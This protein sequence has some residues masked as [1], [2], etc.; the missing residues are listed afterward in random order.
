MAV[1][2]PGVE[3][4][5][6]GRFAEMVVVAESA[7]E[8]SHVRSGDRVVIY[9]DTQRNKYQV[10]GFYA[11]SL[12]LG[13]ET[14]IVLNTPRKDPN[15]QPFAIP[16][17]A[18]K[19]ADTVIDLSSASWIYTP[20]FSEI[21]RSG[22]RILSCMSNVDS[23]IK[24]PPDDDNAKQARLAAKIIDKGK[25]IRVRSSVGTD[26]ILGKEG[27]RGDF[28]DGLLEDK[29]GDWDNFPSSGCACCSLENEANGK[30]VIDQ[31]DILLQLKHF[32]SEPIVCK[33]ESGRIVS[34]DGGIDAKILRDWFEQWDDPNSYV[35]SHVGF[36]CDPRTELGT[37]QLMEWEAY[38]GGLLIAFGRNDSFFTDGT[39]AS[40]SHLD[41]TM[42]N[43]DFAVDGQLLLERGVI[44]RD[45]LA[46]AE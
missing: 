39:N 45:V 41:I 14:C 3:A 19:E 2:Y 30:L 23:C 9:T 38:G 8:K 31:G 1:N 34:I 10:D 7:L 28:Q 21:L 40:K 44:Q 13:A 22:T 37:M 12:L 25:T 20:P 33:I 42:L 43:T 16:V 26:L 29:P 24:L 35:I 17:A 32:V 18:M 5:H 11:A 6:Y 36:G 27:R 4:P 15:R 46:R